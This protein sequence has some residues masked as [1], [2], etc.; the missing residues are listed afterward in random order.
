M[1]EKRR[2]R[3]TLV[4]ATLG[5]SITVLDETVVFLALPAIERDLGIGLTGQQ[6]VVN[7][8]LLTLSAL[9]L[10]GGAL[11]DLLG[12]KRL[13]LAG[14]AGFGAASLAAGLAPTGGFLIA[15]RL[16]QGS[17]AALMM[18]TTLALLIASFRGEERGG[19]IG[20]WA[21]W[22]GVAA[23]IGPLVAGILIGALSWRWVFFLSLPIVAVAGALAL[24]AV[25]ESRDEEMERSRLDLAGGLFATLALSGLSFALIQGPD[26]GWSSVRVVAAA[27]VAVVGLGAFVRRERRAASPMLPLDVFRSRNFSAANGATLALYGAFHGAFF[28]LVIYLQTALGYSPLGAG[29]ATL[30]LTL[31]MLALSPRVGRVAQRIGARGPMT[32]GTLLTAAGLFLLSFLEPRDDYVSSVLPGV[33]VFGFGLALTVA[34]LTN[35]AVSALPEERAG[36]ASGVNNDAAR[37]A[38][39][40]AV[41]LLGLVF[42]VAFRASLASPEELPVEARQVVREARER[43]TSALELRIPE[44]VR[45]ELRPRLRDASID[46]YRWAM[47]LGAATALVASAVSF[48]GVRDPARKEPAL[49]LLRRRASRS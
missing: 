26:A 38:G 1:S 35:T 9:L 11:A 45:A 47:L 12:R 34:P 13:F 33:A 20:S 17:F 25:E 46:G 48:A 49:A 2:K 23:A 5:L 22:S 7:G 42:A 18:P 39:L 36:L 19:A 27:G 14:L 43:P 8:Y 16:L 6:W 10:V 30:P 15:A 29:A 37:T 31:L 32:A 44:D 28:I 41:A 4:A 40:L 24:W 21:A 3:W